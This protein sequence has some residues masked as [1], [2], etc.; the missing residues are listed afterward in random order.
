MGSAR[1]F[2][3]VES[4]LVALFFLQAARVVFAILLSLFKLAL[5]AN[6]VSQAL[7]NAHILIG[8]AIALAWFTPRARTVLPRLLGWTSLLVAVA[9]G[10]LLFD[11]PSVRFYA[12]IA[13]IALAGV[14]FTTLLRANRRAWVSGLV[15]GITLDQL[16]RA[17]DSFFDPSISAL[18]GVFQGQQSAGV[19]GIAVELALVLTL[20]LVG[21]LAR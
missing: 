10:V 14:Y 18:A 11:L 4:S 6:Q 16:L 2:R 19:L 9:R 20:L 5:A 8:F 15:V 21:R 13:T 12:G 1:I 17:R 7:V 3:L